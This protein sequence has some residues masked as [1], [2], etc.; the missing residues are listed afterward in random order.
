[1]TSRTMAGWPRR[2]TA[3]AAARS[4]ISAAKATTTCQTGRL[5]IQT[6]S[7]PG[8]FTRMAR[9]GRREPRERGGRGK[10]G[11]TLPGWD[12]AMRPSS[13]HRTRKSRVDYV[14]W[15]IV[16]CPLIGAA[17]RFGS[18]DDPSGN[19][20]DQGSTRGKASHFPRDI[21]RHAGRDHGCQ[22]PSCDSDGDA[23]RADAYQWG[24]Q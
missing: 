5:C 18:G 22:Q 12:A 16:A 1:M 6:L 10:G 23:D 15:R 19:P 2:R 3:T 20:G 24:R 9:P 8:I 17:A 21:G 11:F 13:H 7:P 4:T 14:T